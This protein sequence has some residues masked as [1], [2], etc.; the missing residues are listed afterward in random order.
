MPDVLE[1]LSRADN[2]F[3][4]LLIVFLCAGVSM[5]LVGFFGRER[6]GLYSFFKI[7]FF[8]KQGLLIALLIPS[9]FLLSVFLYGYSDYTWFV[10]GILALFLT[11]GLIDCLKLAIPDLLNFF[12]LFYIFTGLYYF[13]SLSWDNFI[14]SATLL[15]FFS[16]LRIFGDFIFGKEVMGEADLIIIASVGAM[17]ALPYNGYIVLISAVLAMFY[18]LILSVFFYQKKIIM[19]SQ[20]KIPFVFF[21]FLGFTIGL[22]YEKYPIFGDL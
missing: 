16:F 3:W 6:M 13:D 5:M 10:F 9:L 18:I 20:I 2:L 12:L 15:G 8:S 22:I 7:S 11:L 21:L 14:S 1:T 17:F 4:V 19:I